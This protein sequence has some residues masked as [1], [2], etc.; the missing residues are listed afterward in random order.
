MSEAL[1]D[2]FIHNGGIYSTEEFN[3]IYQNSSPSIYEVIRIMDGIPLFL[4]EHYER[5]FNSSKILGLKLSISIDEIKSNIDKMITINDIENYNIKIVFNNLKEETI[6]QYYFFSSS[7]YPD[8][9]MYREGIK[10]IT[11]KAI[12]QNPNAKVLNN[13][14]RDEVTRL[15]KETGSYEALL[16]NKQGEITE[17]SRSNTFFI[18]GSCVY[19]P[20]SEGV[21]LGI[22]RQ[23]IIS[24]CLKN[25]IQIVEKTVLESEL[26]TFDALFMSGTSPKVLPINSVNGISFSTHNELLVKIKNIYNDEIKNYIDSHK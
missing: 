9:D 22:T 7:N 20:P 26:S 25:N 2:K 15:L 14:L 13:N 5:F 12:R 8:E 17:G 23:R 16:V 1:L 18:K 10:T 4:E 3:N 19:T 11:Y 6:N 24:L 21:L